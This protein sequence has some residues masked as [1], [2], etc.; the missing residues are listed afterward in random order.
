MLNKVDL[1]SFVLLCR[2]MSH[3]TCIELL[4]FDS[5]LISL[6]K[7]Q[8]RPIREMLPN[9]SSHRERGKA[10]EMGTC[11]AFKG[12]KQH[13]MTSG[14]ERKKDPTSEAGPCSSQSRKD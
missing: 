8:R 1:S 13:P 3:T 9:T 6:I 14:Q 5:T 12:T 4:R 2:T 11:F 10:K 7:E